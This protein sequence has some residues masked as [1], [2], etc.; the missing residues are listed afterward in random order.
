M[1]SV[2]FAAKK[3]KVNFFAG[4]RTIMKH[5]W[6]HLVKQLYICNEKLMMRARLIRGRGVT[7]AI[8]WYGIF[9]K[10]QHLQIL[11]G[12]KRKKRKTENL[13]LDILKMIFSCDT[14]GSMD[15]SS[16]NIK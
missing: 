2:K 4:R 3:Q 15:E 1:L 9:V 6:L 11:E 8:T 5:V 16:Q 14:M 13:N 12:K 10:R 7:L